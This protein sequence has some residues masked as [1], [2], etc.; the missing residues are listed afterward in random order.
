MVKQIHVKRI[1]AIETVYELHSGQDNKDT[2]CIFIEAVYAGDRPERIDVCACDC[3]EACLEH[4]GNW[5]MESFI[6]VRGE[7]ARKLADKFTA[8]DAQTLL[9]RMCGKFRPC[10]WA[11]FDEIGRWL[12]AKG[13]AYSIS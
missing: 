8:R 4:Y 6:H 7:A 1:Y 13:I 5:G 11:A 12:E 3:S 2:K 10:G 9:D